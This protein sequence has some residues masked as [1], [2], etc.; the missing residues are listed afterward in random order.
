VRADEVISLGELQK[1]FRWGYKASRLAQSQ[2]LPTVEL[3]RQ[4]FCLGEDVI[5]FFRQLSEAQ[6]N[7]DCERKKQ[8]D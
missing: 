4:K 7:G 2:G 8:D 6:A 1:R 5:R 3:G